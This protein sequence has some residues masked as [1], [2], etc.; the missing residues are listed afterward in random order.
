MDPTLEQVRDALMKRKAIDKPFIAPILPVKP[1]LQ[2]KVEQWTRLKEQGMHFNE[3]LVST[4]SFRNPSIMSKLIDFMGLTEYGSNYP[5]HIFDP[6][7]F[8][9]DAFYQVL[10]NLINVENKKNPPNVEASIQKAKSLGS[11]FHQAKRGR[12][13]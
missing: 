9:R 8:S 12:R 3:K 13:I 10:G 4:Q 2:A 1:S 11:R 6:Q 7:G 5:K